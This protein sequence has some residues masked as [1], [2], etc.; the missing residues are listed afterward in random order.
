[1][2]MTTSGTTD[3]PKRIRVERRIVSLLS[4]SLYSDFPKAIREMVSNAYDADATLVKINVDLRHKEIV[5][6][7]NG[8]GMSSDEFDSYLRI[9][10]EPIEGGRLSP[11]F[12]RQR[13]GRFGVGFLA[14]F[15]FCSSLELTSKREGSEVGFTANIPAERFVKGIGVEEDV[16]SIPVDGYNQAEAGERHAPPGELPLSLSLMCR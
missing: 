5:V 4:R 13:I 12:Q 3:W 6:E 14:S 11:K 15:P 1:M 2:K 8:N 10:G 7:D 9:A 16:S